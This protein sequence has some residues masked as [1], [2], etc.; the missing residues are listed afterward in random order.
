MI[1]NKFTI[2][3]KKQKLILQIVDAL[4][5]SFG[6]VL[7]AIIILAMFF[8]QNNCNIWTV[9]MGIAGIISLVDIVIR[10]SFNKCSFLYVF[11]LKFFKTNNRLFPP[12]PMQSEICSWINTKIQNGKG[13]LIYGKA[14]T[15]KTT[16]IFIYLSQHTKDKDLL[17]YL[18]ESESIIY[19]DCKNNKSDILD[20]FC[21]KNKDNLNDELY[22]NSLVIIDNI[23]TMGNTFFENLLEII[24]SS[25][26]RFIL[27]ADASTLDS[28]LSNMLELKCIRDNCTLSI[29]SS[30]STDF[31][32]CYIKLNDEEKEIFLI[33]YYISLSITL[34]PIKDVFTILNRDFSFFHFK[35]KLGILSHKGLIKTFPFDHNYILLADRINVVK[36]QTI[37]W[38]SVQNSRAILRILQNSDKFPE[39][40]WLSMVRLPYEQLLQQDFRSREELF[41]KALQCGNYMTLYNALQEELDYCPHKENL[42]LYESGTLLFYNS[43]QEKAFEKYNRFINQETSDKEK[44]ATILRIVEATHGDINPSTL[45]NIQ[46]YLKTLSTVNNEC[47][48][49]AQYWMLHIDS[50]RGNFNIQKYSE[51]LLKLLKLKELMMPTDIYYEIIKRCYTDIIR[52]GYILKCSPSENLITEFLDFMQKQY[53]SMLFQYYKAL[54]I[55]AHNLHYVTLMDNI[56]Q[57][58]NCQDTYSK[59]ENY[60]K[61][62]LQN[63]FENLK[64]VTACELK[65]IDLKLF[66]PDNICEFPNYKKKIDIF[67]SNAEINRV[68]VH[69]AYCKTLLAK[70]YMIK[71]LCD[72]DYYISANTKTKNSAIKN[73]LREAKKIYKKFQNEYGIVRIDFLEALYNFAGQNKESGLKD[74]LQKIAGIFEK[75]REYQRELEIINSL[76]I[77]LE[78]NEF[79]HMYVIAIIKAYPIIMQ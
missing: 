76:K 47:L 79:S 46:S 32:E 26:G 37:F 58:E 72:S 29:K 57:G 28:S 63:G 13:I 68:S 36:N 24:N 67:L 34:V 66:N 8:F 1:S 43:K 69:I 39:S 59:A 18:S 75:H 10:K 53:G 3:T 78:R 14:N 38:E 55:D 23:E 48:L 35:K 74:E 70:L 42:F 20:Y 31:K 2:Y 73:H 44:Y 49:Y 51:L 41:S 54:Y 30:D 25:V 17:Q 15:G 9:I 56:L 52:C 61:I 60:Y 22:G 64:S 16:S 4:Q 40:A 62:A 21:F 11:F 6:I 27:L 77:K 50:E 65:S 5:I 19:I 71:N 45:T 7:T 33:L 12:T